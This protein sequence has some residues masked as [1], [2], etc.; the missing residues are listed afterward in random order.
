MGGERASVQIFYQPP[1]HSGEGR[2]P[3]PWPTA[4][5]NSWGWL[6]AWIPAFAGMTPGVWM[7]LVLV[8]ALNHCTDPKRSK[9]RALGSSPRVTVGGLFHGSVQ[10]F[11]QPPCHSGEGRNPCPWPIASIN[12]RGWP[13]AWIPAFA[14]MTPGVWARTHLTGEGVIGD[15]ARLR[16]STGPLDG[17][18]PGGDPRQWPYWASASTSASV[19]V[20]AST[21]ALRA[22]SGMSMV[23]PSIRRSTVSSKVDIRSCCCN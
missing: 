7:G 16:V 3:G 13:P 1:C 23:T 4:S 8:D 2:N 22:G 14:G 11:H 5:I 20:W 21:A 18:G 10:I 6:P 15:V 17:S 19:S 9:C 12:S